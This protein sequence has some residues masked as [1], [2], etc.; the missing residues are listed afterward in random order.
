MSV[1]PRVKVS[2][3]EIAVDFDDSIGVEIINVL[4]VVVDGNRVSVVVVFVV[5]VDDDV[6]VLV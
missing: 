2:N 5:V 6:V 1:S 3:V 4:I